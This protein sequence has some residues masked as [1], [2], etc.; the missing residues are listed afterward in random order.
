MNPEL[1]IFM[2]DF[3][4]SHW[5]SATVIIVI[6]FLL[7]YF[8]WSYVLPAWKLDNALQR[9]IDGVKSA[10]ANSNYGIIYTDRVQ[11]SFSHNADL[12]HLWNEYTETIHKQFEFVDKQKSLT[13]LR[14]TVPAETFFNTAVIVDTKLN[15]EFFK[16][17]P[18]LLTGV[19]IIGTFTGLVL[20]L[21]GLLDALNNLTDVKHLIPG[22]TTLVTGVKEAFIASGGAIFAAMLVTAI[23]KLILNS[24]YKQV[25]ELAQAVDALYDAGAGEE[26]LRELVES[27]QQNQAHTAQLKDAMVNDLKT[28]LENLGAAIAS[29]VQSAI[30]EQTV[31]QEETN[32][33]LVTALTDGMQPAI[34]R[35]EEAVQQLAGQQGAGVEKFIDAAI[36]GAKEQFGSQLRAFGDSLHSASLLLAESMPKITEA[37]SNILSAGEK[38]VTAGDSLEHA[39]NSTAKNI[40]EAGLRFSETSK[41]L[42]TTAQSI[43][44]AQSG[45]SDLVQAA[46]EAA[47]KLSAVQD[48][49]EKLGKTVI[50]LG[51]KTDQGSSQYQQGA[52]DLAALQ[53]PIQDAIKTLSS[54]AQSLTSGIVEPIQTALNEMKR[55]IVSGADKIN[56]AGGTLQNAAETAATKIIGAGQTLSKDLTDSAS[57]IQTA[58]VA[59]NESATNWKGV[60]SEIKSTSGLLKESTNDLKTA[61][62][63][64]QGYL[65]AYEKH[66]TNVFGL[67]K[68]VTDLVE[69]AQSCG[70]LGQQ[71]VRQMTELV[72]QM[73]Q[74]QQEAAKFGEQ[75][76]TALANAYTSF[77]TETKQ[78]IVQVTLD[79]QITMNKAVRLINDNVSE[80]DDTLNKIVQVAQVR[81]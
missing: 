52:S 41:A 34:N 74:A 51:N 71:Q 12:L 59:F 75:V 14:A 16:H 78:A 22:L 39:G 38:M 57:G 11:Q 19:G 21:P 17:L 13:A 8:I 28:M 35:M 44:Q 20:A 3:I 47:S 48:I 60:S 79:H 45:I 73:Q 26:Y 65:S 24:R 72:T 30:A 7:V 62:A 70:E 9:A 1:E 10:K 18:G 43:I 32:K 33:Q 81:A 15:T 2:L 58:S 53:Q 63:T 40:S 31:K 61:T 56:I 50:D 66:N 6:S 69:Q 55:V 23:E 64:V 68:Q 46:S 54:V 49:F 27:S 77:A 36:E 42:D 37:G 29:S 67:I 25:E 80:L 4:S 5:L 76:G